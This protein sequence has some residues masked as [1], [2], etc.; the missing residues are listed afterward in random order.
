MSTLSAGLGL[1]TIYSNYSVRATGATLLSQA[2]FNNAQIMA[3]T[4]HKSVSSLAVYQRVS[5]SEKIEM[6]KSI[7]NSIADTVSLD[8]LRL[9][10]FDKF[11]PDLLNY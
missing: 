9:S 1:P 2:K 3:V 7:G 8:M 5:D 11:I 6:G 4:G 10:D